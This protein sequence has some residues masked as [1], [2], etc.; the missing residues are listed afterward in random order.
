[1]A[2]RHYEPSKS[3]CRKSSQVLVSKNSNISVLLANLNLIAEYK[4]KELELHPTML[5][6]SRKDGKKAI[7]LLGPPGYTYIFQIGDSVLRL[8]FY[9]R[10]K[11]DNSMAIVDPNRPFMKKILLKFNDFS[12]REEWMNLILEECNS[13]YLEDSGQLHTQV[14]QTGE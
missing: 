13:N 2:L 6:Y 14:S 8:V 4:P 10:K 5:V 3:D 12:E 9:S 11:V 1:M 7:Y